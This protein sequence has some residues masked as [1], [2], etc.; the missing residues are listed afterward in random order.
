MT[1]EDLRMQ[2]PQGA[3]RLR[4]IEDFATHPVAPHVREFA[5]LLATQIGVK[6]SLEPRDFLIN[7]MLLLGQ[8]GAGIDLH[9][10]I[11]E[12]SLAGLTAVEY[13]MIELSLPRL[14][15]IGADQR[16]AGEVR[17]LLEGSLRER[18]LNIPPEYLDIPEAEV[19]D[20]I[21]SPIRTIEDVQ[22][23]IIEDARARFITLDWTQYGITPG[24]VETSFQALYG[25][26]LMQNRLDLPIRVLDSA[27]ESDQESLSNLPEERKSK[28]TERFWLAI[29]PDEV[30]STD[31]TFIRDHLWTQ[32]AERTAI[33]YKLHPEQ[34]MSQF[35]VQEESL[36]YAGRR[37]TQRFEQ[38][39]GELGQ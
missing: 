8:W 2:V 35:L 34:V 37:M 16:F 1:A 38:G 17:Q 7:S 26:V 4:G 12:G 33:G 18:G 25:V 32:V 11:L 21:T 19:D 3:E 5:G 9:G 13:L 10:Q 31:A 30:S 20:A 14:A 27:E 24:E 23:L 28:I 15:R 36:R 39:L 29:I 6:G 22:A